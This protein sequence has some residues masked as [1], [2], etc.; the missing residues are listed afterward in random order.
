MSRLFLKIE[1]FLSELD[2]SNE[3]ASLE[4]VG[5]TAEGRDLWILKISN[6]QT[7]GKSALSFDCGIHARELVYFNFFKPNIYL[8]LLYYSMNL[9][10]Y[11]LDILYNIM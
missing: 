2:A 10:E 6:G 8:D 9:F 11:S 7:T 3:L 1:E 4:S 5:T